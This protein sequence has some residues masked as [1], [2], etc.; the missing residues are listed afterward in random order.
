MEKNLKG[1]V[2]H[3]LFW[4]FLERIGGQLV[5]LITSIIL[6][7]LLMPEDYG[8]IAIVTVFVSICDVLVTSGLGSPLIQK[9]NADELDFSTIFYCSIVV[10]LLLYGLVFFSAPLV[11][12]FYDMEILSPVLRV[13]GIRILVSSVNAVQNA[14]VSRHMHFKK[15]FYSTLIGNLIAGILGIAMAY[16]GFGVWGL[17]SQNLSSALLYM[18][19]IFIT[20]EWRPTL[21]F[22]FERLKGLWSFGW[23]IT[24]AS[25]LNQLY[26]DLRT[27]LIGKFYTKAEL[28][29]YNQGQTYPTILVQSVDASIISVLF[30]AISKVQ[31]NKETVKAFIRR[32]IKVASFIL[33]PLLLGFAVISE[34]LIKL[35]LTEKWLPCVPYLQVFC[36]AK[37]LAPVSSISQQAIKAV[38]RSDITMK[39]EL[40]KKTVGILIIIAIIKINVWAIVIGTALFEYWCFLVNAYPCKH[41]FKYGY[42]QQM[43][44]ILPNLLSAIFMA[45]SVYLI[46]F[47]FKSEVIQILMQIILGVIIYWIILIITKNESYQYV[48]SNIISKRLKK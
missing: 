21:Q 14:Y 29:Y 1:E 17:V 40:I 44:D 4:K 8:V 3:G 46:G 41:I 12:K 38:G 47:L 23:R 15:F 43:I 11:A 24:I 7:R 32:S 28:S 2:V 36:I 6:A 18:I 9:K 19:I 45:I 20:I 37:L 25:L 5:S 26:N 27:L 48:W 16:K 13:L 42:K 34:P 33:F 31:D 39:Q 22:S 30:P 35:L 10:C